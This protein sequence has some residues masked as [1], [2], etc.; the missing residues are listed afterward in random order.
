[1]AFRGTDGLSDTLHYPEL[2]T[3][4]YIHH[5]DPLLYTLS[6]NA[7]SGAAFAF[8]GVSLGGGA[9]NLMADICS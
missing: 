2:L 1:V 3:G 9:T 4:T 5:Y 7:P 8:T 6:A